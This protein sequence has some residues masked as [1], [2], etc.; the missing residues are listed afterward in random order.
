ML[1]G[2]RHH[3]VPRSPHSLSLA[4]ATVRLSLGMAITSPDG[5]EWK[6]HEMWR[7]KLSEA[8]Y[9][10]AQ[11]PNHETKAVYMRVLRAFKDLV[12]YGIVPRDHPTS[13]DCRS[14]AGETRSPHL[15]RFYPAQFLKQALRN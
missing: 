11:N 5:V 8:Q 14:L 4:A 9:R 7:A 15:F 10:Y 3:F 2:A 13:E 12:L 1:R 6:L